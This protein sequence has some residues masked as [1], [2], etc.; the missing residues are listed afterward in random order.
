MPKQVAN[1]RYSPGTERPVPQPGKDTEQPHVCQVL[2]GRWSTYTNT[3]QEQ[4]LLV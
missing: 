2:Y 4:V 1:G 3:G